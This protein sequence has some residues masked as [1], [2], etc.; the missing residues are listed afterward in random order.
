MLKTPQ[1]HPEAYVAPNATVLG[2]V[3]M[4]ARSSVLFGAVVR[5]EH[6]PIFIGEE[7]NIQDNCVLHVDRQHPMRIGRGCTIGHGAILHSCTIGDDTLIG[8]GAIVLNGAVIGKGCI[9]GAGAL[10]P[11]NAVIPD[12][13]LALGSPARVKRPVTEEELAAN[14]SSAQGYVENAAAF[15][16]WFLGKTE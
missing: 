15:R 3:T 8:M 14:R 5:A 6:E 4:G 13:T 12:G 11:Q 2:D 9:I 16:A 10:V 1:I 7:S